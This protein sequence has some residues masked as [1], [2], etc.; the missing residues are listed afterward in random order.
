MESE[1]ITTQELATIISL[2]QRIQEIEIQK[3]IADLELQIEVL[4]IFVRHGLIEG[5]MIDEATGK[6]SKIPRT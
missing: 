6:I 5:D 2:K 4:K 1:S 3:R